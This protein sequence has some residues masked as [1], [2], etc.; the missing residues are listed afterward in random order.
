[1]K[2]SRLPVA[3]LLCVIAA[4]AGADEVGCVSTVFKVLGP[5]DKI[6]ID[7]FRDPAVEG[8]VCHVSR[9]RT[10]GMKGAVGLA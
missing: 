10:G 1:M 4:H 3:A 5:N 7:S 2:H 8:V 6:C 9:A